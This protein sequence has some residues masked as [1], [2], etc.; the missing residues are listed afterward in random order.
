MSR[1][2]WLRINGWVF[3]I[4][5]LAALSAVAWAT[6]R[7]PQAWHW[8]GSLARTLSPPSQ[9]L[10]AS[11]DGEVAAYGFA[12]PG[13]L[14]YRHLDELLG[15][16]RAETPR[17]QVS[18][19]N[20]D[21]RPDLVRD[22]GIERAGEVVLEYAG[23]HERV[24]VPSEARVSAALE[25]LLR[26]QGQLVAFL[27]GHGE[28]N[29]LGEANHDLGAFGAALQRKGY[30][31]Q[32]LN[33]VRLQR[34]PDDAAVLVLTPPQT[35]LLPGE[36]AALR[37]YLDR[38]GSILWLAD[39]GEQTPLGGVADTLGIRW[40]PGVVVDPLAASALAVDDPRL[41]LIDSYPVH[42]V[43]DQLRA[44]VLL[45]QAAV[46]EPPAQGWDVQPL[47]QTTAQQSLVEG[48]QPGQAIE[49]GDGLAGATLGITLSRRRDDRVQ[50]IA[51]VGD[52]DFLSNSYIGNGAN[53]PFGLNLVDWLTASELFLDSFTR[54]APDQIVELGKWQTIGLAGGLLLVL[55]AAFLAL[56]VSRWWRRSRG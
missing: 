16:Y 20:P 54:P 37:D 44:P 12:R 33:L 36:R 25:R 8:D 32:P 19:I 10:L 41:V 11:L 15:L 50:R 7:L 48:F 21:A 55:P 14:L 4:L 23:R 47:L 34:I 29:L 56:A 30:R 35:A 42:A 43:T 46:V 5:L 31:L 18:L 51:I 27:A 6:A 9:R 38:G 45:A 1:R 39:P 40:R 52:G 53:L 22:Y 24:Q 13:Q 28:R 3:P 2:L 26:G 17:F 49:H